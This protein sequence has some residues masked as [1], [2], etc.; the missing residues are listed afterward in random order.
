MSIRSLLL[1]RAKKKIKKRLKVQE[2]Q[3]LEMRDKLAM[4]RTKLANERTFL[5]YMRTGTAMVLAGLTFI[6]VFEDDPFYIGVGLAFIPIGLGITI[7]GY[8]R[9]SKKRR[10]VAQH[11]Y[12]YA[13]T[14]TAHAEVA[15]QEEPAPQNVSP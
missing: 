6:K 7:F 4:E 8:S 1:G 13:P 9:F 12:A 15:E 3:N 14:S 11:T 2:K 10:E 5:S